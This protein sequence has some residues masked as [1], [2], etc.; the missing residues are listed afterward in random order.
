MEDHDETRSSIEA[1]GTIHIPSTDNSKE[2]IP[3]SPGSR[4]NY[5]EFYW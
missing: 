3:E 5:G 4:S 2:L 1:G